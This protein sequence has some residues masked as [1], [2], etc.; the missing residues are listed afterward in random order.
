MKPYRIKH[1]PSGYYW[2]PGGKLSK[3]GKVFT[4]DSKDILSDKKYDLSNSG[5]D[6][7]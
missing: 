6:D 4:D 5:D 2:T 1:V 7:V 3:I